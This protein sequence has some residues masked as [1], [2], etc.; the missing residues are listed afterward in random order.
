[1]GEMKTVLGVMTLPGTTRAPAIIRRWLEDLLGDDH[2][3]LFEAQMCASEITNN[4]IEHTRTGRGGLVTV[5]VTEGAGE[6]QVDISDEGGTT[7]VPHIP[8]QARDD[9]GRGLHL[10]NTMSL[11][12]GVHR[13]EDWSTVW[14]TVAR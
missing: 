10:V 7:D 11:R 9:G 4:T 3:R 1:M 8:S 13:H 2:P 12:W 14:F 6:V 5:G